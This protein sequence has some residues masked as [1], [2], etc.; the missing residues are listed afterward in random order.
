LAKWNYSF[1]IWI[2]ENEKKEEK[3]KEKGFSKCLITHLLFYFVLNC[4]RFLHLQ[5]LKRINSRSLAKFASIHIY[6]ATF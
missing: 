1:N 5:T 3:L 4:K 6:L 2:D